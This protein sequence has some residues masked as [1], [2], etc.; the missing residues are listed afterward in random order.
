MSSAV[1]PPEVGDES[2]QRG[3]LALLDHI[4]VSYLNSIST[5]QGS[6]P[7]SLMCQMRPS[8]AFAQ[9]DDSSGPLQQIPVCV[10]VSL[11]QIRASSQLLWDR[12]HVL[13]QKGFVKHRS[14]RRLLLSSSRCYDKHGVSVTLLQTLGVPS[15]FACRGP[16]LAA[17]L[18]W[19]EGVKASVEAGPAP[20]QNAHDSPS[21]KTRQA[22][23]ASFQ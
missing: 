5:V 10:R 8:C 4:H 1:L 18:G 13:G 7:G 21:D 11:P 9:D 23:A 15:M 17:L 2:A 14:Q 20:F 16:S 12:G 3:K 6:G 19:T 22:T